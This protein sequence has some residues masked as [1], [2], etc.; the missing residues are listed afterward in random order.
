LVFCKNTR[1]IRKTGVKMIESLINGKLLRDTELRTGNS[2]KYCNFLLSVAVGEPSPIVVSGIAFNE[3]AERIATLKKGDALTVTG[4][5]KPNQWQDKTSGE[6]KH[7]LC[8]T[9][10]DCLSVYDVKKR[11]AA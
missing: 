8:V 2:A 9:V 6:T 3:I 7:G 10:S 1:K 11:K 5:L 4:T